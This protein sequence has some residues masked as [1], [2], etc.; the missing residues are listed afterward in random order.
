MTA[1]SEDRENPMATTKP[2]S[3]SEEAREPGAS[4]P[5]G[6]AAPDQGPKTGTGDSSI[7]EHERWQRFAVSDPAP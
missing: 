4:A 5:S 2:E 6:P 3:E 7:K 1:P